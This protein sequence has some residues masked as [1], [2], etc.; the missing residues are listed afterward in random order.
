M[1]WVRPLKKLLYVL[2]APAFWLGVWQVCAFLVDRRL[3]GRGNELLLPYPASVWSTFT[4]M[5]GTE[6]FWAAVLASLGRIALGLC[7]GATIGGV[8]AVLT[9]ASPWADRLL[10][11]AIRVVRA[12][13]VASFILLVLLWTGRNRVPAVI[14]AMMVIPVVWDNLSRGIQAMDGKLLELARCYRFSRWKTASLIYLPAL[15]PYILTALTTAAGLAWK[16]GVAAE[17]LCLP[18]PSL[19]QRIYYT[20]YYLDIPELFAWTAAT[21]ALSMAL[22]RLLRACLARW[23]R[24]WGR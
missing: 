20:K 16:S 14:A 4:A 13:P 7:W 24:G 11:P 12:A 15:R 22:E 23:G 17:V 9:C 1:G 3:E 5:V 18:E 8:L 19:G 6:E 21:V 10:S 2:P